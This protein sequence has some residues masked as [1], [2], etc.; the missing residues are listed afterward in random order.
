VK[1][2]SGSVWFVYGVAVLVTFVVGVVAF[3]VFVLSKVFG[4]DS[5][6]EEPPA[7]VQVQA[8][9]TPSVTPSVGA[10]KVAQVL[11]VRGVVADARQVVVI[12]STPV[13][14]AE[15]LRGVAYAEGDGAVAVRVTQ[16]V[17]GGCRWVRRPVLVTAKAALGDRVVIVNGVPW[18]ATEAGKYRQ[19]L[20]T[21]S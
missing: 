8:S 20:R 16:R 5:A 11:E 7:A 15:N 6:A 9:V 21:G 1:K 18:T 3:G 14:C 13:G 12:V 19:A 10:L 4:G 17:T 2:A